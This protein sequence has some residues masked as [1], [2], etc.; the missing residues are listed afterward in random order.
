MTLEEL[1]AQQATLIEERQQL[2][3]TLHKVADQIHVLEARDWLE[4]QGLTEAA[5]AALGVSS[6]TKVGIPG[7]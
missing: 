7:D 2:S 3:D 4:R 1:Y 5:I 6:G